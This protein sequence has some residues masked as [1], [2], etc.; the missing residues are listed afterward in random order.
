MIRLYV[1]FV[2]LLIASVVSSQDQLFFDHEGVEREYWLHIPDDIEDN[3]P[4]VFVL[5]GY[6][7]GAAIIGSYSGMTQQANLHGFA[8][9]YPQGTDDFGGTPHWN[10]NLTISDTDDI[11]FL[12]TL[13]EYLQSEYNL[14]PEHTFSCG[15]SNGGFMSYTLACERPDVFKAIASVT[16]TM[17]GYDWNNC[18]PS[19]VVPVFQ[20]S[21]LDD[22]VVPVDGSIT[23]FGGWGGAPG[24]ISVNDFWKEKNQTT[25]EE[26]ITLS[27][28]LD[29]QYYRNGVNGNEVWYYP[30]ESWG[31]EWPGTWNQFRSGILGAEEIWKFFERVVEGETS[32]SAEVDKP[33]IEVIS[34]SCRGCL[35]YQNV[36]F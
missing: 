34:Y 1:T 10:A 5:H 3:A 24:A 15:M 25:T 22:D 27:Q 20:I 12:S 28:T 16:G 18:D 7:S 32:S 30:I 17:S 35:K 11:G 14:N 26:I 36:C 13:A 33:E 31:H 29:A 6:T 23:T 8:V 19:E 4:L 9:C 2:L 21:G